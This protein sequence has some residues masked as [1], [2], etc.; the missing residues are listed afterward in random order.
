MNAQLK[1]WTR[2]LGAAMLGLLA[3]VGAE[4]ADTGA[5]TVTITPTAAYSIL[6]DTTATTLDLGTVGLGNSTWTLRPATVTVNS[7]YATTELSLQGNMVAGGWTFDDNTATNEQDALKA[8]AVFTDTGVAAAPGQASGYFSGT[9]PS[10][11]GSDVISAGA[12]DVG[13]AGGESKFVAATGDAGYKS[14]ENIPSNAVDAGAAASHL[15]LR[16]TLPPA[17]TDTTPKRIQ[18]ILTAFAGND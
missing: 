10:V 8:W 4:A 9:T 18:V 14:M 12:E 6:I 7:S 16:F 15:W 2:T 1:K 3:A 11:D 5:L 17:T 13:T